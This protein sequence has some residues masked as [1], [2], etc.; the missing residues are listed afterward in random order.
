[1]TVA[2]NASYAQLLIQYSHYVEPHAD[3][4]NEWTASCFYL[5]NLI[6]FRFVYKLKMQIL[7]SPQGSQ[8]TAI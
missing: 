2:A 7:H 1:M 8:L 6:A 5:N 4:A 3:C